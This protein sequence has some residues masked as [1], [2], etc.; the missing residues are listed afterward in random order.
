MI[1]ERKKNT[2]RNIIFGVGARVVNMLFNFIIRAVMIRI[3]GTEYL[4]L[5]S[6]FT[7]ILAVLNL[8]ELGFGTAMVFNMYEPISKNDV[9]MLCA[10]LNLYKKVY[11]AIGGI[12]C[13][14][15]LMLVPFLKYLISGSVPDDINLIVVYLINLSGTVSTYWLFAYRNSVLVAHQ[16][17]DI[18]S[19]VNTVQ[20]MLQNV[21][22]ITL[23]FLTKNYYAYLI[24]VPIMTI[25]NNVTVAWLSKSKYPEIVPKGNVSKACIKEISNKISSLF[26]YKVGS[27]VSNTADNIVISAF[28]GLTVVGMYGNYYY[29]V[30]AIFGFLNIYYQSMSAGLGNKIAV[31][32]IEKNKHLFSKLYFIQTWMIGWIS[33]C[34]MCLLQDFI[35]LWVGE[36]QLFSMVLPLLLG[37]Y[38]YIWKINDIVYIFKDASGLWEYDKFRPLISSI[39]NLALNVLLV[40][41]IGIYGVVLST[42]VCEFLFTTFWGCRVLY[43]KYFYCGF[44]EYLKMFLNSLVITIIS[45]IVTVTICNTLRF[46]NIYVMFGA[47]LIVCIVAPNICY[48]LWAFKKWE[49]KE[50]IND[51]KSV[52]HF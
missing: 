21:I 27:V 4:G 42:I 29:I 16:R 28:L 51:F 49:F 47:K 11:R 50:A 41:W 38:I 19:K 33:I 25:F 17:N 32:S 3:L 8:A 2:I 20:V 5:N 43:D 18:I 31:D 30:S 52:L 6:L 34:V 35:C 12:I 39:C 22:Q 9:G 40:N 45:A 37:V 10:L 44:S 13:V 14:I 48:L 24:V 23:L 26:L 1:L 36:G 46:N 7:S 15:G